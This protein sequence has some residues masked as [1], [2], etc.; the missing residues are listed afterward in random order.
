MAG[1]VEQATAT[2]NLSLIRTGG[3]DAL[4]IICLRAYLE[5]PSVENG[6]SYHG[7]STRV[8]R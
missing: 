8:K 1:N 3:I 6:K 4:N 7:E 2:G 5:G